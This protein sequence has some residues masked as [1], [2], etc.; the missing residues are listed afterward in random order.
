MSDFKNILVKTISET[1]I[2]ELGEANIPP[3][4]YTKVTPLGYTFIAEIN[5]EYKEVGVI[6]DKFGIGSEEWKYCFPPTLRHFQ[7][8][9]NV[10]YN[11]DGEDEQYAKT[12]MGSF[13]KIMST[14]T[15]I[16]KEFLNELSPDCL[17]IEG[18][19]KKGEG[20]E[21]QKNNIYGAFLFQQLKTIEGYSSSI[22]GDGYNMYKN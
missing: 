1:L 16:L 20:G 13:L 9:Y 21:R 5:D 3:Y 14:V 6:F 10:S 15:A 17:Y 4:H 22:K 11:V 18:S 2:K 19:G 8:Y 12:T 7:T